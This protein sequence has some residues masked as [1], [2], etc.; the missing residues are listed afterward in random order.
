MLCSKFGAKF[1]IADVLLQLKDMITNM[2]LVGKPRPTLYD[3]LIRYHNL[4]DIVSTMLV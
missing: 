2:V 3:N 4:F 1:M